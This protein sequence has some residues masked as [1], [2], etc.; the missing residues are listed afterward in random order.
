MLSDATYNNNN[1]HSSPHHSPV[2]NQDH[3]PLPVTRNFLRIP[4]THCTH[5]SPTLSPYFF[6]APC[7]ANSASAA[8]PSSIFF[9]SAASFSCSCCL[10]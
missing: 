4:H 2:P 1:D 7:F 6:G 10:T 9:F 8:L 5:P 3:T